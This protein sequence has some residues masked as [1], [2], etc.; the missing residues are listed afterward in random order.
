MAHDHAAVDGIRVNAVCPCPTSTR[1]PRTPPG[2][3][4][5]ENLEQG[6]EHFERDTRCCRRRQAIRVRSARSSVPR[7]RIEAFFVTGA[8]HV[9]DGGLLAEVVRHWRSSA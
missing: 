1:L 5:G 7:Q 8:T 2:A 4:D 9:V 6:P 3:G